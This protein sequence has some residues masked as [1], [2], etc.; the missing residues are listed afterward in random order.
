MC[1]S[2]KAEPLSQ[3]RSNI[4]FMIKF[5]LKDQFFDECLIG[6]TDKYSFKS[7]FS[8]GFA[9]LAGFEIFLRTM[10]ERT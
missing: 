8:V 9:E 7:S 10:T 1:L 3:E 5:E 2:Q 6:E 4:F